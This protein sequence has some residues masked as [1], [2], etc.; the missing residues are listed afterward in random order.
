MKYNSKIQE[1]KPVNGYE[2]TYAV[3]TDGIVKMLGKKWTDTRGWEFNKEETIIKP[4]F[5]HNGYHRVT[6]VVNRKQVKKFQLHRLVAEAFI[7][8]PENK[9][10]VNHKN[11][12][13]TDNRVENLEWATCKENSQHAVINGLWNPMK[14]GNNPNAK[15]VRCT[16]FGL[17]FD[18]STDAAD[19]LGVTDSKVREVAN[20]KLK[21]TKGLVFM[22][23]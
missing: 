19:V 2:S 4:F 8:N 6:L 15:K 7:P 21:H 12:I 16:T 10:T 11:G 1:W 9:K 23:I 18:C 3:S 20:N 17:D 22:F 14:R 13:K 5:S